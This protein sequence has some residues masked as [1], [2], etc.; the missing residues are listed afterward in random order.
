MVWIGGKGRRVLR[1]N[2]VQWSKVS[3]TNWERKRN[4]VWE[5]L[6]CKNNKY[7]KEIEEEWVVLVREFEKDFDEFLY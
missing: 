4:K 5:K 3:Y 6:K 2:R 7:M 1:L